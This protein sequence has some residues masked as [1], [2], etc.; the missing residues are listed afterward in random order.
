MN[1]NDYQNY[2]LRGASEKYKDPR[3]AMI[4]LMGE[5]GEVADVIKKGSIYTQSKEDYASKLKEEVGDYLWQTFALLNSLNLSF[6]EVVNS[7]VEK[8]NKRHGGATID[9]TGGER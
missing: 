8:L 2:V 9:L 1:V 7:N 3:F 6:E 5:L 4:A